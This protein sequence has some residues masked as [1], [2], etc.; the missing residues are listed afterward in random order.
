MHGSSMSKNKAKLQLQEKNGRHP[1]TINQNQWPVQSKLT[2][3]NYMK[4]QMIEREQKKKN[5]RIKVET[6]KHG[7]WLN[8]G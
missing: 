8:L 1:Q 5:E 6:G 2:N 4:E 3:K 7:Q